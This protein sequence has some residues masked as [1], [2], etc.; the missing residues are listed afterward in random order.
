MK[1]DWERFLEDVYMYSKENKRIINYI[2]KRSDEENLKLLASFLNKKGE[3]SNRNFEYICMKYGLIDGQPKTIETLSEN[4]NVSKTTISGVISRAIHK[5]AIGT[6]KNEFLNLKLSDKKDCYYFDGKQLSLIN[7]YNEMIKGLPGYIC[8]ALQ[9]ANLNSF[10]KLKNMSDE[11]LTNILGLNEKDVKLIRKQMNRMRHINKNGRK[12][13]I[14]IN[15]IHFKKYNIT[16]PI[17]L[18]GI[19]NFLDLTELNKEDLIKIIIE[20][21]GCTRYEIAEVVI[22]KRDNLVKML[23]DPNITIEEMQDV[24]C[25][26]LSEKI[27]FNLHR[28]GCHTIRSLKNLT[29]EDLLKGILFERVSAERIIAARDDFY[30]NLNKEEPEV[31]PAEV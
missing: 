22:E 21:D 2:L 8:V 24:A 5:L 9:E 1:G 13:V 10:D 11:E 14:G 27:V 30:N 16:Y 3:L 7:R 12:Y 15:S 29:V 31:D 6:G 17:H 23:K 25:L 19:D 28:F 26:N 20:L 18:R 4:L